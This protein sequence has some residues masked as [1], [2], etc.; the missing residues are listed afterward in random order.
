M[1]VLDHC[2]V[3][4]SVPH[5]CF[6]LTCQLDLNEKHLSLLGATGAIMCRNRR[7]HVFDEKDMTMT[8]FC[9]VCCYFC[10]LVCVVVKQPPSL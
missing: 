3:F 8:R 1:L 4:Y 2:G 9:W 6:L 5:V 10:C 7:N